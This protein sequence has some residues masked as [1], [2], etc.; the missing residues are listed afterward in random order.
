[1]N[2]MSTCFNFTAAC[3]VFG[4]KNCTNYILDTSITVKSD[5]E[6][7][8]EGIIAEALLTADELLER[9]LGRAG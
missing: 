1:M 9:E 3:T 8:K 4:C 5:E 6:I 7:A 2:K